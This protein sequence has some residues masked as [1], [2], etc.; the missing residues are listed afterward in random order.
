MCFLLR[1]C[2]LAMMTTSFGKSVPKKTPWNI[3]ER[4]RPKT[5][6]VD[7]MESAMAKAKVKGCFIVC[8]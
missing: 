6:I 4:K 1:V 8:E 7:M 2:V 3:V 5:V